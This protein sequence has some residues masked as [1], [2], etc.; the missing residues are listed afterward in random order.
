MRCSALP[1]ATKCRGSY[2]LTSGHGSAQS[3]VGTAFHEAA[4][5]K[6]L[7]Q[8][9]DY[10]SLRTRYGLTDAEM[11]SIDYGIYNIMIKIPLG[12]VV[13]ADDKKMTGLGGKLTGTPDLAIYH[14]KT[15]TVVDWKSGWGDVEDPETNNQLIG[16]GLIA[17][18]IINAS[19]KD[20]AGK[21]EIPD[22]I[23]LMVV[24]PRLDQ[25]K[26]FVFTIDQLLARGKD[27]ESI[28]DEAEDRTKE[29]QY[30]T[31]PWCNSCF[32][33]MNCPAFAGQVVTF[34]NFVSGKDV[35]ITDPEQAL[36]VL[37][38]LSKAVATVS[39]K[40]DELAKAWVDENGP[41]DLGAGQ[42]YAKI[43]EDKQEVNAKK[44]F[45]TLKEF[46]SEEEIWTVVSASWTKV[47]ELAV[48]TKRGLSTI[49]KNRLIEVGAI[50]K[51][52]AVK[53]K[54]IKGGDRDRIKED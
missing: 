39:R 19:L 41:L 1:L 28:I 47:S 14:N 40:I 15:L 42:T 53:Y 25:V 34:A 8:P 31:G 44:T 26:T 48:A 7:D 27:I 30:T 46:F 29:T 20:A 13:I 38:P 45:E 23:V 9:M 51:V 4:R 43:I 3:R 16:Y 54:I 21:G 10:E 22:R 52:I 5:A 24:L 12:A 36:R 37:L 17:V 50:T 2:L 6:V 49:V 32:K 18:E 33:S 35:V 11:K